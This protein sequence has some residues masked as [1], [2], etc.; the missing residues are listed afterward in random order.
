MKSPPLKAWSGPAATPTDPYLEG[1]RNG[2]TDAIEQLFRTHRQMVERMVTRLVGPSPDFDDLVQST[3]VEVIRNL[4][5][6]RGEAKLSTWIGGIAVHVVQHHLRAGKIRRHVPLELVSGDEPQNGGTVHTAAALID[7]RDG[8]EQTLDGRRLAM[9]LHG[10]L[11]RITAKK[12]VALLLYVMEER[13]VEEIAALM[14]ATQTA[15]RSRVF[16][17]RRELRKLIASDQE[18]REWA[19]ALLDQDVGGHA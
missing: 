6:F 4:S 17:A 13:S 12:R 19:D 14:K 10:L 18:L 2:R 15:T 9:R 3:F 8:A 1:C 16:F 11:D 7:P 5:R